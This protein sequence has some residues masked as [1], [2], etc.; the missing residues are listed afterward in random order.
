M[1]PFLEQTSISIVPSSVI[2]WFLECLFLRTD[3]GSINPR[4]ASLASGR[5]RINVNV[6][7]Q[8]RLN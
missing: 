5:Q 8:P 7:S 2:L 6:P 4:F 1:P 3:F